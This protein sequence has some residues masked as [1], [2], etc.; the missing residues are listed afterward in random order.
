MWAHNA[1]VKNLWTVKTP[2]KEQTPTFYTDIQAIIM[3][4]YFFSK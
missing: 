1:E 2:C 4:S 3:N